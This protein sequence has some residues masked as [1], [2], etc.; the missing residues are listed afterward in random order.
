MHDASPRG[1]ASAPMVDTTLVDLLLSLSPEERLRWNDRMARTVLE[2]R[3]A[4]AASRPDDAARPPGG[5]R[6]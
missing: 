2:L 5:E 1:D 3:D 6:R 4:F